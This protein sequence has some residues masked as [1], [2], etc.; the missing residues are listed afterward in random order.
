MKKYLLAVLAGVLPA[1]AFAAD[2]AVVDVGVH[3][4]TLGYGLSVA[5]PVTGSI[6]GRLGFNQFN[7][8]YQTTS[9][10]VKY[11]GDL[12]LSSFEALVDWHPFNGVTHLT[13]GLMQNGN[14]FLMAALPTGSYT[15]NGTTYT[16]A[17][18][19]SMSAAVEFSKVVPYLGF[20]WSGQAK[21]TGF[22]FKS[23]FGVMFQ[24]KP[25]SVLT[26]TN[27]GAIPQLAA[28]CAAAQVKMDD[29]LKNFKYYPVISFGLGYAF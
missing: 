21:N 3:L 18:V 27:P 22:S 10:S 24:G 29:D 9:D 20:G 7:K 25:K 26:C 4:S 28:D 14:K 23:D 5:I 2:N 11:D 16:A 15:I 1:P 12:K 19:G 6:A 8:S 13:A 17:Q